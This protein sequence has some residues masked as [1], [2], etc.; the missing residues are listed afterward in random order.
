MAT[1]AKDNIIVELIAKTA[2]FKND[3]N[4]ALQQVDRS[5]NK[6]QGR[7]SRIA[8]VAG[9][10][11][12]ANLITGA[13]SALGSL[14]ASAV[15]LSKDYEQTK[16][17]FEV[18]T[19]SVA[20]AT[21]L[22]EDLDKFSLK[23][24]FEPTEINNSAKTLLG[25]GRSV[26]QVKEDLEI[27]GEASAA[28]GADLQGLAVVFGQVAGAGKLN[29]GDALQL[30]NQ[31]VPVYDLLSKSLGKS[32]AELKDLQAQG[33][34]T[35][36]DLR[37]AFDQARQE[38]GKF[39]N[40]LIKQSTTFAGLASTASGAGKAIL[41]NL[42]DALLPLVREVLPKIIDGLF[43]LVDVAKQVSRPLA[44]LFVGTFRT[45]STTLA[46]VTDAV[47]RF[48][49]R[50]DDG[51]SAMQ[52]FRPILDSV[53]QG[54][55]VAGKLISL[56]IDGIGGFISALGKTKAV[57]DF[58]QILKDIP[59]IIG[60]IIEVVQSVPTIVR[61]GFGA[62]GQN[63]KDFVGDLIDIL[64]P[65]NLAGIISGNTSIADII[66]ENEAER[67]AQVQA[68]LR[69]EYTGF[70]E[71]ISN[72]YAVGY[73][74]IKNVKFEL[75]ELDTPEAKK[76]AEDAGEDVGDSFSKGLEEGV[77]KSVAAS[78]LAGVK[79]KLS[80]LQKELTE[81]ADPTGEGIER[82]IEI[83]GEIKGVEKELKRVEDLL[84][85]AS[86]EKIDLSVD[87]IVEVDE[88]EIPEIKEVKP[89]KVE[90]E[91]DPV[92]LKEM[93]LTVVEQARDLATQLLEIEEERLSRQISLQET[94]LQETMEIAD[95]GNAEQL[96]LEQER[97]SKLQTERE[98]AVRAK[99]QLAA[100]EITIN[101]AVAASE[102]IR[103]IT[104]AFA[105]GNIPLGI[106][107]AASLALTVAST[108]LTVSQAFGDLPAFRKGV[109]NFQ[110][111]ADDGTG[112]YP[113][114]LHRGERVL[115]RGQNAPLIRWGVDNA[116]IPHLVGVG[117]SRIAA[118]ALAVADSNQGLRQEL[119]EMRQI[120]ARLLKTI[121]D[122]RPV[123]L[124]DEKGLSVIS[125]QQGR[126][127][128]RKARIR[129]G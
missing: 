112:G 91:A 68:G 87:P 27:I 95:Q 123:V 18:L 57:Q 15:Q 96:Q 111:E 101:N 56:A 53:A 2:K 86:G 51:R 88:L 43:Y 52:R 73:N 110:P 85:R 119:A 70:G 55:A 40:A 9:G 108:V 63:I 11:L 29:G 79:K 1:I 22:L 48:F 128:A 19:G 6:V 82:V 7:F 44:R 72:A 81:I 46:P 24:P 49:A 4:K 28:T 50:F 74:K 65:F 60:G 54:F 100:I 3:S 106:A 117:L 67:L 124:F 16:V 14:G 10:V 23:T 59:A 129:R 32:Q 45:I 21:T 17:S 118:P 90:V 5:A 37:N 25:F 13:L 12:S 61:E 83:N 99:Q 84:R 77:E 58:S 38:G 126:R 97:L 109:E 125:A 8:D 47:R 98:K 104:T 33:K 66:A 76:A 121:R 42:G 35:F 113:A 92:S 102:A 93:A 89:I 127:A 105:T 115:T 41:R 107:T 30:I 103:A 120:N 31:G 26:Q 36:E 62:A 122:N 71:E 80:E 64:N 94:R 34:I 116:D 69:Q 75:P 78:S 39:E 114:L 20:N